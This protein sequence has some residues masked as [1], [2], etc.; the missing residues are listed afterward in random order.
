M[1]Q[2][3]KPVVQATPEEIARRKRREEERAKFKRH[4]PEENP[5]NLKV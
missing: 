3:V 4:I 2:H 5:E 1:Q